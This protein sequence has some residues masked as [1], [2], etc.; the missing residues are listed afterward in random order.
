M[1]KRILLLSTVLLL[2]LTLT[3][4]M[5]KKKDIFEKSWRNDA[6]IGIKHTFL[7]NNISDCEKFKYKANL[8]YSYEYLVRCSNDGKHW[9]AYRVWTGTK[10]I[11]GPFEI[12]IK[13]D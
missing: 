3:G 8:N 12:N 6:N 11:E 1:K 9:N 4:C 10:S 2:L 5:E 7:K 13:N